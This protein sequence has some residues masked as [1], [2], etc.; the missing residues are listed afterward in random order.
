MPTNDEAQGFW[1]DA[2][3]DTSPA[4]VLIVDGNAASREHRLAELTAKGVRVSVARTAFEGIVKAS[5]HVP[6]VILIDE[7]LP[8]MDAAETGRLIT[9]CPVTAHIPVIALDAQRG[10]P[11]RVMALLRQATR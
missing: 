6:D 1:K 2:M 10:V 8:D 3:T 9:T 7:A 5:C 11:R 4:H